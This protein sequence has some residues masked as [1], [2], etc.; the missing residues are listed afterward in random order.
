[1]PREL[2]KSVRARSPKYAPKIQIFA[3]YCIFSLQFSKVSEGLDP[4]G[5]HTH[6]ALDPESLTHFSYME[7][8]LPVV[9]KQLRL[10]EKFLLHDN[11]TSLCAHI[12]FVTYL[13]TVYPDWI[14]GRVGQLVEQ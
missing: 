6:E 3:F 5:P 13:S 1:M 11:E 9:K 14:W 10:A 8:E 12:Y 7:I 2:K 4:H